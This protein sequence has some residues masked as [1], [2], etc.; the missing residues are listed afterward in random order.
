MIGALRGD[1][2]GDCLSPYGAE[3]PVSIAGQHSNV[4]PWL[5]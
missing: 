4:S 1:T 5:F 3:G 2:R